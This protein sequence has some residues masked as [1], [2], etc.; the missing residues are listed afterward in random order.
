MN[1]FFSYGITDR[2]SVGAV[3]PIINVKFSGQRTRNIAGQSLLQSRQSGSST[4]LGDVGIN[5]RF[6]VAGNGVR[7]FSVGADL[8]T[9][10]GRELDLL[11]SGEAAGRMLAIGSWEDGQL[12]AHMNGGVGVGGASREVFWAVATTFAV[13]PRLTA[14]GEVMG[15]R[16][17]ELTRVNDVYQPHPV[18][19]GIETMRWLPSERG[20]HTMYVVTGA[21]WN[22][23]GSWLLNTN[24]LTRLSDTGLSARVTPSISLDY[25]FDR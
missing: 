24:L 25:G 4:G 20:L 16:L 11:G 3:V 10:T 8:R 9:P 17:S 15:R 13:T 19:V 23:F 6:L 7:G 14:I 18:V 12:A 1:P 22:L 2:L 5:T 21:K